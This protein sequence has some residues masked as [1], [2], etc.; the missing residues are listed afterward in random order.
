MSSRR[1]RALV[2]SCRARMMIDSRYLPHCHLTQHEH[3]IMVASP[4]TRPQ[5]TGRNAKAHAER[6]A[7]FDL[8]WDATFAKALRSLDEQDEARGDCDA[9]QHARSRGELFAA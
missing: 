6:Q 5:A 1:L 2:S 7:S 8:F 9:S 3:A 4:T